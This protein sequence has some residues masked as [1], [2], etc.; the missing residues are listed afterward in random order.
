MWST[1]KPFFTEPKEI[2]LDE[3][4]GSLKNVESSPFAACFEKDIIYYTNSY[5]F[6]CV[7]NCWAEKH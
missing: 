5:L 1:I 6:Y 3:N 4:S 7:E 2:I